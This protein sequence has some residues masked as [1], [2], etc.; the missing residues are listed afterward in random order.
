VIGAILK[1]VTQRPD[2]IVDHLLAYST[3]A[4]NEFA[5]S[6][7][8]LV[9]RALAAAI[10]LA[11]AFSFVMLAGVAL[12]LASIGTVSTP[13]ILWAVPGVMLVVSIV[14]SI[15]ALSD[16]TPVPT[17]SVGSQLQRDLKL[18]RDIAGSSYER[19]E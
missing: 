13:W 17:E 3:L 10:G 11:S 14:A 9:R 18:F 19:T 2:L 4:R 12:M 5:L 15:V 1:L 7:K 6:K 8:R 16:A